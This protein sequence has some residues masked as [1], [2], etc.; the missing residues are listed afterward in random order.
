MQHRN[1]W[2]KWFVSYW[3]ISAGH[4][5]LMWVYVSRQRLVSLMMGTLASPWPAFSKA[6]VVIWGFWINV[7]IQCESIL[8]LDV[9]FYPFDFQNCLMKF[10]SWVRHP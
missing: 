2:R 9:R 7:G 10:A 6:V 3:T 4:K 1:T 8:A 5:T